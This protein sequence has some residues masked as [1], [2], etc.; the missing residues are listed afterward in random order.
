MLVLSRKPQESIQIGNSIRITVLK[1][2]GNRVRI[3][4]DAPKALTILRSE[5]VT[6]PI[7]SKGAATKPDVS[8][9]DRVVLPR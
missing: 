8:D 2:S 5:L 3:A 6:I 7:A 4:L 1:I 9:D